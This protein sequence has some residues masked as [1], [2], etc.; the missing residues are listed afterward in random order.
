MSTPGENVRKVFSLM[1]D[2]GVGLTSLMVFV[3]VDNHA[4]GIAQPLRGGLTTVEAYNLLADNPEALQLDERTS[5]YAWE[6]ERDEVS[7]ALE[8]LGLLGEWEEE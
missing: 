8:R 6:S 5:I 3:H 7:D 1:E 4:E 2:L